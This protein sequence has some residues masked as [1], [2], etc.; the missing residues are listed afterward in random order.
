MKKQIERAALGPGW[1][2]LH[3]GGSEQ[4]DQEC[5]YTPCGGKPLLCGRLKCPPLKE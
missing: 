4:M 2:L 3:G 5:H 1:V